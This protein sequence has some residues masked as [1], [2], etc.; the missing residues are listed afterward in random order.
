[1]AKKNL[2]VIETRN[3]YL[4]KKYEKVLRH[5]LGSNYE[6]E[7]R[8]RKFVSHGGEDDFRHYCR[9]KMMVTKTEEEFIRGEIRKMG[10]PSY[11]F[12]Y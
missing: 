12:N 5:V 2:L 11:S 4:M 8:D 3:P 6:I 1:M 10:L 9:F 7:E